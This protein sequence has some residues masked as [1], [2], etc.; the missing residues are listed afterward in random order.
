MA[1]IRQSRLE[2]SR[3]FQAKVLETFPVVLAWRPV[4]EGARRAVLLAP[5]DA[6]L[7]ALT[8]LVR[9]PCTP[10]P[11]PLS[12]EHGTCKTVKTRI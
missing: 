6:P 1:R 2:C 10:V 7:T 5:A 12:S 3:D 11:G 4:E 9:L 8:A